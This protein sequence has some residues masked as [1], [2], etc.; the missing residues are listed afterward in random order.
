MAAQRKASE[1]LDAV[2]IDPVCGAPVLAG[3]RE[4]VSLRHAGRTWRFCSQ[5]CR[6]RFAREAE[7][8]VLDEALRAGRLFGLR[9]RA[10]WGT[11]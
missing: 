6:G 3:D 10:R 11:A 2:V 1:E 8:A 5:A 9:G 7:R 4:T